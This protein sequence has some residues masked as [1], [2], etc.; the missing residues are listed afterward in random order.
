MID[1]N[2]LIYEQQKRERE[3]NQRRYQ[4]AIIIDGDDYPIAP[5]KQEERV[6]YDL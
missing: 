3:Q 4:E 6:S 2:Y 5:P 1:L